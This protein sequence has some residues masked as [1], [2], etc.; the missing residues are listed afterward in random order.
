MTR[1][2]SG[3]LFSIGNDK[4][5][6]CLQEPVYTRIHCDEVETIMLGLARASPELAPFSASCCYK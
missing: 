1:E 6:C 2:L 4:L 5:Q 3:G